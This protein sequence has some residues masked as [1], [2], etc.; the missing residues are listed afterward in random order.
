LQSKVAA[1]LLTN[2][3]GS[4][5]DTSY[6]YTYDVKIG[7][8]YV[9]V[10]NY[11]SSLT[12]DNGNV[13]I[14]ATHAFQQGDVV[15][16]NAGNLNPLVSGLFTVIAVNGTTDF[17][18]NAL[19]S[20]VVDATQDGSVRY[21][22]NR[23]TIVR[24][25][26]TDA[27]NMVYDGAIPWKDY[28]TYNSNL[29]LLSANTDRLLTTIPQEFWITD[30]QDIWLYL[31]HDGASGNLRFQNDTNDSFNITITAPTG[32]AGQVCVAGLGLSPTLISGSSPLVKPTT[33]Y[34]DV[35]WLSGSPA[36]QYSRTYRFYIDRRC[37]IEPYEIVFKDRL[38]SW[39]SFAFSLRSYKRGE[40]NNESYNRDV[41]GQVVSSKWTYRTIEKGQS[42]VNPTISETLE[43]NSN[44]MNHEAAAYFAELVSSTQ[45]YV[46]IDRNYFACT[47]VDKGYEIDNPKNK[48]LVRKSIT[49][50][51]SNQDPING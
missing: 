11:T 1:T 25:I 43:L 23:K 14:T 3:T 29:F 49:I 20:N 38:G 30:T 4:I 36:A 42:V 33:E 12:D 21:S 5:N 10:V 6:T 34:Y 39:G 19:W 17:T 40:V 24:N 41:T 18:I 32:K 45:T 48:N 31:G 51:L 15:V 8:K 44:F 16:V 35:F 47:I 26:R 22:D 27:S 37:Q 28:R 46:K 7:E 13:N 9:T 2:N 50:K